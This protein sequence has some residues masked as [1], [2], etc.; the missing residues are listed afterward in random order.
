M[1]I[2][3]ATY[4]FAPLIFKSQQEVLK[5]NDICVS[6]GSLKTDTVLNFPNIENRSFENVLR[7]YLTFFYNL[8]ISILNLFVFLTFHKPIYIFDF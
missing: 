6:W 8:F 1:K 4:S 2:T 3:E 5:F 7:K